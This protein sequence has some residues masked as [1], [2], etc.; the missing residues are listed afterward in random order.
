MK[1]GLY[2]IGGGRVFIDGPD[3]SGEATIKGVLYKWDFHEYCGPL[4]LDG[5]GEPLK[6]Q[7][8]PRHAVWKYFND[9]LKH[10]TEMKRIDSAKGPADKIIAELIKEQ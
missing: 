7:P 5:E 1:S 2:Q 10:R 3:D 8:G 9:W 4:F 6:K